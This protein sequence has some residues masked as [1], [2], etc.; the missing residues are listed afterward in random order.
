MKSLFHIKAGLKGP[1]RWSAGGPTVYPTFLGG[2]SLRYYPDPLMS[3]GQQ[4]S[5]AAAAP[6][7]ACDALPCPLA[8]P[9]T[10]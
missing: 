9:F 5:T 3:L 8:L 1:G 10:P 6:V 2:P 7:Q 4:Q